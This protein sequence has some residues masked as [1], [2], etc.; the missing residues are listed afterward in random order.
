MTLALTGRHEA[1]EV[2]AVGEPLRTRL[3]AGVGRLAVAARLLAGVFLFPGGAVVQDLLAAAGVAALAVIWPPLREALHRGARLLAGG[4]PSAGEPEA[5][6]DEPSRP[7]LSPT[8][9]CPHC[10]DRSAV[11]AGSLTVE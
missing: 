1:D 11:T 4:S 10:A 7:A 2:D 6:D 8:T 3:P 9:H 5:T